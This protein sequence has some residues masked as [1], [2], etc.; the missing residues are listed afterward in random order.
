M[1][2]F[3]GVSGILACYGIQAS[4]ELKGDSNHNDKYVLSERTL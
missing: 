2:I 3:A 4:K 1:G